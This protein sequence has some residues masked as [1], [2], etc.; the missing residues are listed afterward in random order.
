[1]IVASRKRKRLESLGEKSFATF[2]NDTPRIS[3]ALARFRLSSIE[4]SRIDRSIDRGNCSGV[5]TRRDRTLV[6]FE[7][8]GNLQRGSTVV[9][10]TN[11][12]KSR[13]IETR[14][15]MKPLTEAGG[16]FNDS[17]KFLLVRSGRAYRG[18][19]SNRGRG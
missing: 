11:R 15:I 8:E 6:K 13:K 10:G 9:S 5:L 7:A 16:R 2:R 12:L 3:C 18:R 14:T 19:A 4:V 17:L 1:M